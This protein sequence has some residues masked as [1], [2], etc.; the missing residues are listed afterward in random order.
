MK[1]IDTKFKKIKKYVT[2]LTNN[3]P[4]Y[5]FKSV[6]FYKYGINIIFCES[7]TSRDVI[8]HYILEFFEQKNEAE[9]KIKDVLDFVELS[10]PTH[11]V[12][13]VSNYDEM[14]YNLYCGFTILTI[15]G[16]KEALSIETKA[17]LNSSISESK[18]EKVLKGPNDSFTENY[19]TNIGMIRKRLK[20]DKLCID[21]IIV[22]AL[23]KNKVG[24][25]YI[26]DIASKEIADYIKEKIESIDIDAVLDSNYVIDTI[27]GNIDNFFP[28][29]L[30]TERPDLVAAKLLEGKIAVVVENSQ[31]VTILPILF[32]ELF[33]NPEDYYQTPINANYTRVIRIFAFLI[34]VLTPAIYIAI[35]DYNHETIPTNLLINFSTQRDGVPL[36]SILEALIMLLT[37]EILRETD[38]RIPTIIGSSLSIVGALVLGEAAVTAGVVSPIMVIVIAITS[39]S[40]FILTYF[41]VSNGSRWWRIIFLV[42]SAVAG[43]LG[44]IIAGLMFIINLAGT[45]ALGLPYLTPLSPL[46]PKDLTDNM[47]VSKKS[48]FLK[49]TSFFAK[50]N[51][52]KGKEKGK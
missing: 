48:K 30:P 17:I 40:G 21:E 29:Y 24:I 15:D 33:H 19:Q 9:E 43:M 20:T 37:F 8:N 45:Q 34:T 7:L 12:K 3:N 32:L 2:E 13:R 49:R 39:I 18:N 28:T 14:M 1:K 50:N 52:V 35:I 41:D 25:L 10:L 27:N 5:V 31:L 22:G 36:P 11:K 38:A 42:F 44:V 46:S 23:S 4:D 6:K 26:S 47:F 16:Y 51:I